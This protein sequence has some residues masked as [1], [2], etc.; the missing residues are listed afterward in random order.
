MRATSPDSVLSLPPTRGSSGSKS[1]IKTWLMRRP[2]RISSINAW[3]A[4][5]SPSP[6]SAL[7]TASSS[8]RYAIW[9]I[10]SSSSTMSSLRLLDRRGLSPG[11][12][13]AP[14]SGP[15]FNHRGSP[16]TAAASA[17]LSYIQA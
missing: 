16:S 3:N 9:D 10:T 15:S 1:I 4:D 13:S 8:A 5:L 17:L 2:V 7:G 11:R 6:P 14:C 12:N